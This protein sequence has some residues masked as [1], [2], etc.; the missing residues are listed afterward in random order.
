M[1]TL[2]LLPDQQRSSLRKYLLAGLI[3]LL[4]TAALWPLL[5]RNSS[6]P[7]ALVLLPGQSPY[8]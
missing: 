8:A 5:G 6:L 2:N 3:A 7:A 1:A 4:A